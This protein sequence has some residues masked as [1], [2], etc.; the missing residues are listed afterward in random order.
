MTNI[1]ILATTRGASYKEQLGSEASGVV[2]DG[3]MDV[4]D[5]ELQRG[6]WAM[7]KKF[8]TAFYQGVNANAVGLAPGQAGTPNEYGINYG[9]V[10]FNGLRV[11]LSSLANSVYAGGGFY[12]SGFSA[13]AVDKGAGTVTEG[14]NSIA[15]Q[16][17]DNGGDPSAIHISATAATKLAI[18]GGNLIR[19]GSADVNGGLILGNTVRAIDTVAGQLPIV[20]VPGNSIG[21][22][23]PSTGA[24]AGQTVEDIY[25]LD[26][27]VLSFPFLG[28]AVPTTLEIPMGVDRTLARRFLIF[29]MAGF[30]MKIPLYCGKLRIPR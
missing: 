15:Q 18:E 14:V 7:A 1:A 11:S 29:W 4:A 28:S 8:Q 24:Y 2:F 10:A 17:I 27:S 19:F 23:T 12:P 25:V 16:I 5:L 30:A 22:Y 20:V 9:S 6:A 3:G 26:E 13:I 21:S